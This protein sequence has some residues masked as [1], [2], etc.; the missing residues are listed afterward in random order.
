MLRPL[1]TV[2]LAASVFAAALALPAAVQARNGAVNVAAANVSSPTSWARAEVA[3][4][5]VKR[6]RKTGTQPL[7]RVA[8]VAGPA[9]YY[10]PQ[11]FL[12]WCSA[13]GR[14]FNFLM[15]GVAY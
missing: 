8:A 6:A 5:K 10:H 13:G 4:P 14:P 9:R 12:F 1:G 3:T 2:V 7:R 15:L 11:C